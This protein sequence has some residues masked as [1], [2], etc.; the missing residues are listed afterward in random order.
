MS[1]VEKESGYK[2]QTVSKVR[3]TVII[4]ASVMVMLCSGTVYAWSVF[5]APLKS[6]YGFSTTDTQLVYG[7]IIGVFSIAMLFVNKILR[8]YGPKISGVIGAVIFCAGYLIAGM[9]NGNLLLIIIGMSVLS[10][11]GMAFGYVTVL[12]TLVKWFP[13]KRGL[14]TGI[15]VAGFGGGAIMV[16][17]LVS[18]LL[19]GGWTVTSIFR[20]TGIIYGVVFLVGSLLL[21]VPPWYQAKP[22]EAKLDIGGLARDK[23]FWVLFYVLFAGSFAGLLFSGNLKPI[24]QSYGVSGGAAAMGI[25]LFSIGNAAGRISWGQVRDMLGGKK[26][27]VIGLG[28]LAGF[29]LILLTGSSSDVFFIILSILLGLGYSCNFV[30]YAVDCASIWGV[31]RLDITYPLLSLAYGISGIIAPVVGGKIYDVTQ[32]Y[33]TAIVVG[34]V[35]CV[36]AILVYIFLTPK[37][38]YAKKVD[39]EA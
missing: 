16:T 5:V 9:S 19:A 8:K 2:D 10:G 39:V 22:E 37:K 28:M 23:H 34:V 15:A 24:G 29:M 27:L 26:T 36:S 11:I 31:A 7:L 38:D 30:I 1:V 21:S 6:E 32:S 25:M 18:P 13:R 17:L 14:A 4:I 3:Y 12:T 35:V 20:Y 33:S